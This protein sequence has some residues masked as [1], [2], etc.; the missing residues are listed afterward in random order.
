MLCVLRGG[1]DDVCV[2]DDSWTA[3]I[4]VVCVKGGGGGVMMMCVCVCVMTAGQ[5]QEFGVV[6]VK[7]GGGVMCV[8]V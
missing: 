1:G 2:C 8:C 4:G 6:C 7:G 5:Q 3:T